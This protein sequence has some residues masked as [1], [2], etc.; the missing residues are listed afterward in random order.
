MANTTLTNMTMMRAMPEREDAGWIFISV[1]FQSRDSGSPDLARRADSQVDTLADSRAG[2]VV[3][4]Q[5]GRAGNPAGSVGRVGIRAGLAARLR[6]RPEEVRLPAPL[7]PTR[8][9]ERPPARPGP[10]VW[11]HSHPLSLGPRQSGPIW[12]VG[13]C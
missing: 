1:G 10:E 6:G 8:R 4:N 9:A 13:S 7:P 3:D 11:T 12:A 5:A 2:P